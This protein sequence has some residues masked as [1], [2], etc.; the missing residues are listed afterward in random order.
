MQAGPSI[1]YNDLDLP[2][3]LT[4]EFK[5]VKKGEFSNGVIGFK[6]TE[7]VHLKGKDLQQ[8]L[9][10]FVSFRNYM[11]Y[12]L[13]AIKQ[14]LHAK[15]RKRVETF[16][17]VLMNAKRDKEGPKNWRETHGGIQESE[18]DL[19]EQKKVEEVFVHKQ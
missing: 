6:L 10:Y 1:K 14:S 16:E 19:Q 3:G 7:N 15:M 4:A 18:R 13:H 2:E 5:H 11:N 17:R 12:H 8:S 9:S